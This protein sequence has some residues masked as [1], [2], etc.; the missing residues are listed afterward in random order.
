MLTDIKIRG[1]EPLSFEINKEDAYDDSSVKGYD[2][3]INLVNCFVGSHLPNFDYFDGEYQ[4]RYYPLKKVIN[5]EELFNELSSEIGFKQFESLHYL[6]AKIL[7][8]LNEGRE[9][10]LPFMEGDLHPDII[11]KLISLFQSRD[12]NPNKAQLI[13]STN[14]HIHLTHR[15]KTQIFICEKDEIFRLDDVAGVGNDENYFHQYIAGAYGGTPE[16]KWI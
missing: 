4:N 10:C 13:F 14:Q 12:T 7:D 11:K 2:K 8:G 9:L 5:K 1:F 6:V 16:I 3:Y 15:N